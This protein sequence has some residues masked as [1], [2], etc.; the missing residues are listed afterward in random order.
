MQCPKCEGEM[1]EVRYGAG[2]RVINRCTE[3]GGMFFKPEDLTRLKNT[4]KAD[5]LDSGSIRK[6]RQFN[7]VDDINCPQCGTQMDKVSD[8]K[9]THIWYESCPAGC[10]VYFDAGELT[11]LSQDTFTDVIKGWITGRR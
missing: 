6:G 9:Q 2:D 4:Y 5:I 8:E 10:G 3:C 7:K 1:E 11:D